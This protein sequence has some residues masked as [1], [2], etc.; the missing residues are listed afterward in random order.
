[1]AQGTVK[2][3]SSDWGYGFIAPDDGTPDVFV[4]HSAIEAGSFRGIQE[5]SGSSSP[6]SAGPR[7][8]RPGRSARSGRRRETG[9]GWLMAGHPGPAGP[10]G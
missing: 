3:F 9:T 10:S 1:M 7:A 8:R 5:A 6:P 2:W 4:R